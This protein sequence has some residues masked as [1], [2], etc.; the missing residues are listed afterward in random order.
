[1][2][3]IDLLFLP[4]FQKSLLAGLLIGVATG[5]VGAFVVINRMTFL[6][7]GVA[8]AAYGG[9]GLAAFMG[10]PVT[11]TA[12]LYSI[13]L[14]AVMGT[15][16]QKRRDRV[17]ALIGVMWALGMAM[18]ILL[19]SKT[20]GYNADMMSYLFGSILLVDSDSLWVMLVLDV[21]ILLL[22][23]AGYRALQLY[24]FDQDYAQTRGL[25]VQWMSIV[26]LAII[27]LVVVSAIAIVGL[28]LV[29]AL[30]T[31]P[32]YIA[33]SYASELSGMLR[34]SVVLS[35]S[36]C[37]LGLVVSALW[38]LPP[39]ASII[40]VACVCYVCSELYQRFRAT[41]AG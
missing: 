26:S 5:L 37:T 31:I 4:F 36:F 24:V 32:P 19:L 12:S 14:S 18:G 9:I 29:I 8:H 11:L 22:I 13:V 10:W 1:M 33:E 3:I 16:L 20:P 38:D 25:P 40:A 23:V 27:A 39:G 35:V 2:T 41:T 30:L 6:A 21:V 28:V 7:G 17:D 15:V 34:W